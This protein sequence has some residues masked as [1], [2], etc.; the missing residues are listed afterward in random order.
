MKKVT[1]IL[2]LLFCIS[3]C[4]YSQDYFW[5]K[6]EVLKG[7]VKSFK[8]TDWNIIYNNGEF[9]KGNQCSIDPYD[10]TCI[11]YFTKTYKENGKLMEENIYCNNDSLDSKNSFEYNNNGNLIE[12]NTRGVDGTLYSISFYKYDALINKIEEIIYNG[13]NQF[14]H[15][16]IYKK[17]CPGICD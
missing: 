16:R 8:E 2:A 10:E 1:S 15:K 3:L 6:E 11:K 5:N 14:N 9:K 17:V 12:R 4:G 7:K 13:V